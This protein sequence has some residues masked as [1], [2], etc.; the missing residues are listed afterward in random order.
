MIGTGLEPMRIPIIFA[1]HF[2]EAFIKLY[3]KLFLPLV[4]V[5]ANLFYINLFITVSY[6][7]FVYV[8]NIYMKN[9]KVIN[10]NGFFF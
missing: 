5:A 4:H 1:S 9:R 10:C 3:L 8:S 7:F 6:Y 2:S